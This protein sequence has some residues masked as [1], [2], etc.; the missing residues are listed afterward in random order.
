[1][2]EANP[3]APDTGALA[4]RAAILAGLFFLEKVF[5]THFV[6]QQGADAALAAGSRVWIAQH[7][8]FRFIVAFIGA[9]VMFALIRG[10]RQTALTS[11]LHHPVRVQ[12]AYLA[13]HLALIACLAW[14]SSLLFPRTPSPIPYEAVVCLW[15][16]LGA[17]AVVF[18]FAAAA[19][20]PRWA[21][22]ARALGKIWIYSADAAAAAARNLPI[23]DDR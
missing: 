17:A 7:F 16:V 3:T 14:L 20:L 19:P 1:V 4:G 11:F 8:G 21:K 2:S 23:I 9:L 12:P 22:A 15:L 18:A 13:A 6:N 5:L 10:R